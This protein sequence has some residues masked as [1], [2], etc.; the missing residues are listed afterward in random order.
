MLSGGFSSEL[1]MAAGPLQTL[2]RVATSDT[3]HFSRLPGITA[4]TPDKPR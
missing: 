4:V 2:D 3:K 1:R